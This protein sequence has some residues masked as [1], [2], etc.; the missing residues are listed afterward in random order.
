M[1]E[2][3]FLCKKQGFRH[4]WCPMNDMPEVLLWLGSLRCCIVRP[5]HIVHLLL[6]SHHGDQYKLMFSECYGKL[7]LTS[8]RRGFISLLDVFPQEETIVLTSL[9]LQLNPNSTL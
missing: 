6:F 2:A 7:P 8:A 3:I 4:E 1:N 9:F 5:N